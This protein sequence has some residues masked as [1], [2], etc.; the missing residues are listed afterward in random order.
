[1]VTT[2]PTYITPTELLTRAPLG[3]I[4]RAEIP[5]AGECGRIENL[6]APL[7]AVGSI[8]LTGFPIDERD[9][10]LRVAKSGDLGTAVFEI[11][12]DGG[13]T[14]Q[15]PVLSTAN[16]YQNSRWQ[17]EVPTQG[18]IIQATNGVTAPSFIAGQQWTWSTTA[19]PLLLQVCEEISALLRKWA[20]NQGKPID[21]IDAADRAHICYIG[22][23]RLVA[24]RGAVPDEWRFLYNEA[25]KLMLAEAKGDA[26]LLSSPNPDG[27]V[28]PDYER[29]RDPFRT[30]WRF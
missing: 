15:N 18:V 24:G 3:A 26:H 9:F 13:T 2:G 7:G 29:N 11:S 19:S 20:F 8:E 21:D 17:Y 10:V 16:E 30:G 23:M 5:G 28:Y 14:Y 4:T 22:R 27:F 1:M 12:P 25:Q 6:V